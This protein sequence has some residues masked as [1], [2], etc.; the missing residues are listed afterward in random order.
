MA[1]RDTII[2]DSPAGYYRLD[3]ASGTTF[4]D[5][6]GNSNTLTISS[7]T[8]FL[9]SQS[10]LLTGDVNTGVKKTGT[11]TFNGTVAY[12]PAYITGGFS[13]DGWF[14]C[15]ALSTGSQQLG[16]FVKITVG[17]GIYVY[18]YSSSTGI[19][20]Q[21][22][23]WFNSADTYISLSLDTV[24]YLAIVYD[25]NYL[26]VY[27]N[28]VSQAHIARSANYSGA[29]SAFNLLGAA[30]KMESTILDEFAYY[31]RALTTDEITKHYGYGTGALI[32]PHGD[33]RPILRPRFDP[34]TQSIHRLGL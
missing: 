24:Y 22:R 12:P 33:S 13:L 19:A 26:D 6:S 4:A 14:K 9:Y 25:T 18:L 15:T 30:S 3:E 34:T 32:D 23:I 28:N 21:L 7:A 27:L 8:G 2:A 1:Y 5:A 10:G 16:Y 29:V 17:T 31:T 20:N 11:G